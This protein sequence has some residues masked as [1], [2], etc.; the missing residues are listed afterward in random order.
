[1]RNNNVY[2]R[3][4]AEEKAF[5]NWLEG[6]QEM[7]DKYGEA[8]PL[9]ESAY[10]E[11][12]KYKK[13]QTYLIESALTGSEIS[14][15]AYRFMGLEKVLSAEEPNAER[16]AQVIEGLEQRTRD[17]FKNYNKPTDMKV[18]A[19][20]FELFNNDVKKEYQPESFKDMVKKSKGD[21]DKMTDRLFKKTLFGAEEDVMEFLEDPDLKTLMKDPAYQL[22]TGFITTY[23]SGFGE[24]MQKAQIDLAKGN[25]LYV[26]GLREMQKDRK[27]YPNANSTMRLTYGTVQDYYP[28]DA[29]HYDYYTTLEGVMQKMDNDD[30][31]F[32]VPDR[33]V[34]LYA[35]KDY[36]RYAD[37]DGTLHV[38]F[39]TNNDI[40]GG[41]SGSPVINGQGE[42]IGCAFDGNWEAMSGDIAFEQEK[43]RTIVVDIRYVLFV[44]DKFAGAKHLVD[45][46][47]L[48][49]AKPK[50]A[51]KPKE[52]ENASKM[53]EE[54]APSMN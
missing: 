1:M 25:R 14:L 37:K 7:Q 15:F 11:L 2:E 13:A 3:K 28:R 53:N 35:K 22:A 41:N 47:T 46:M 52:L 48:S 45:E 33:L 10:K 49:Y 23:R 42:L 16:L 24:G 39:L 5:T 21:F 30:P 9:I 12:N 51:E 34:E 50:K 27:F 40:T 36:G 31:E 44:I 4:L 29:V 8:L 18:S 54:P 26:A 43:Q 17:H 38:C 6:N 19:A 20:L 32:V